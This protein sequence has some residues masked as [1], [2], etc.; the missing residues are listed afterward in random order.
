ML[1]D[2]APNDADHE[3]AEEAGSS[4]IGWSAGARVAGHHE[5]VEQGRVD[6]AINRFDTL[7]QS[8]HSKTI[9]G[10]SFSCLMSPENSVLENFD[11]DASAQ[12]LLLE[13]DPDL[14]YLREL[15][16]RYRSEEFFIIT[17]SS[18]EKVN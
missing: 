2:H 15:N 7:P 13:N 12:S 10:D 11:L 1:L 3:E 5:D 6:M 14:K 9:W 16:E 17:Y 4:D 8:F 18:K